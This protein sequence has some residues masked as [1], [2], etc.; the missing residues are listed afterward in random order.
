MKAVAA[1]TALVLLLA[2]CSK[3]DGMD[4]TPTLDNKI[5]NVSYN[6]S[7]SSNFSLAYT[8][9]QLTRIAT[10]GQD[11]TFLYYSG[12]RIERAEK[13][14][15][16]SGGQ[17]VLRV[18]FEYENEL[19]KK[20]TVTSNGSPQNFM[21]CHYFYK[22]K[23]VDSV[24]YDTNTTTGGSNKKFRYDNAGNLTGIKFYT[25]TG[26]IAWEETYSYTGK[27][28]PLRLLKSNFATV[29]SLIHY[30]YYGSEL[31]SLH[32]LPTFY[33]S[34]NRIFTRQVTYPF[35]L[36]KKQQFDFVTDKDGKVTRINKNQ[37]Y[38]GNTLFTYE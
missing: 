33:A 35:G 8:G 25:S 30:D 22:D 5:T 17:A 6:H 37:D 34:P 13:R 10:I 15:A 2:S 4:I 3:D 14:Y 24:N 16:T 28:N 9:N 1:L 18:Q 31:S 20:V 27:V 26:E 11:T 29:S 19:L 23:L 38:P 21:T 32:P 12:E 7:I 36:V